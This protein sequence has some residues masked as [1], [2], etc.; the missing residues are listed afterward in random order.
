MV[1]GLGYLLYR[2]VAGTRTGTPAAD[3]AV[4]ELRIAYARGEV[5]DEEYERRRERLQRDG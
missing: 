3:P 5:D 1:V 2:A 4:E